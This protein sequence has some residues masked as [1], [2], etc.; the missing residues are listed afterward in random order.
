MGGFDG[1]VIEQDEDT[2]I[3]GC[4]GVEGGAEQGNKSEEEEDE[5]RHC[6]WVCTPLSLLRV[7]QVECVFTK[8][9]LP[10]GGVIS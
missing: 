7:S 5:L 2:P 10:R 6:S 8:S 9:L 3:R 4:I 1:E